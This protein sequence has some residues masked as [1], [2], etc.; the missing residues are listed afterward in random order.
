MHGSRIASLAALLLAVLAAAVAAGPAQAEVV[1]LCGPGGQDDPCRDG[2]ATTVEGPDGPRVEDPG[3]AAGPDIDCFYVYPTVSNQPT[4]NATQTRDP[5]VVSIA[6]WQ[7]GRF[8]QRCRVFAPV[9][10]QL[11]VASIFT[12]TPEQ[13]ARGGAIAF[14]DVREA[15][16]SYLERHNGGRGVVLIG[17]SQ[18]TRMLRQLVRDEIEPRPDVRRRLVSALLLGGNVLVRKGRLDGG[19]FTHVPACTAAA[20]AGCVVAFSAF[21]EDPPSTSRFGRAPAADTSGAGFPAGPEYEVLC[22]NPASLGTNARSALTTYLRGDGFAPG[23]IF[24]SL[25]QLFRGPPPTAPTPWLQPADRYTGRCEQRNGANVLMIEPIGAARRLE[26]SPDATWGLHIADVNLPLG[27]LVGL[28]DR[29]AAA[30][31]ASGPPR[32]AVRLRALR[33]R[34]C[35]RSRVRVSVTGAD[36]GLV[37]RLDVRSRG[38]LVARDRRAPFALTLRRARAPRLLDVVVVL[39]DGRRVRATRTVGRC[40]R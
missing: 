9:Y 26:P 38:R 6:R 13:R 36:R 33:A 35:A 15:W 2:L 22:T 17:H 11:T 5:E 23:F 25:V 31:Q 10:R 21:N 14:G 18:G 27:D 40:S 30:F 4:T 3:L 7:A 16:R 34:T 24:A 32:L 20:Q 28:V 8:S 19:D 1:W 39:G 37:G 12:G 29:Q